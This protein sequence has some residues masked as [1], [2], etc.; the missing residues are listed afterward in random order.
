MPM[1]S[2]RVMPAASDDGN[3][4]LPMRMLVS[5]FTNG[6]PN[7]ESTNA[8]KMYMTMSEKSAMPCVA[9]TT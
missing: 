1:M 3:C 7:S 5:N 6:D 8:M 2:I 4:H 9:W